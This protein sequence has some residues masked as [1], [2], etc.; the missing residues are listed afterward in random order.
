MTEMM[1]SGEHVYCKVGEAIC[2]RIC[3]RSEPLPL[4]KVGLRMIWLGDGGFGH[5][6]LSKVDER[7]CWP[8]K[9]ACV[10][11]WDKWWNGAQTSLPP[12]RR[13]QPPRPALVNNDNIIVALLTEEAVR[14]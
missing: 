8:S 14:Q 9:E 1:D 6:L 3:A 7:S 10:L 12:C 4:L 11:A 2:R 5:Q 13:P